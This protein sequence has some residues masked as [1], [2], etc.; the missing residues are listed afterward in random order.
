MRRFLDRWVVGR[1]AGRSSSDGLRC[2]QNGAWGLSGIGCAALGLMRGAFWSGCAAP[3]QALGPGRYI[4]HPARLQGGQVGWDFGKNRR[5]GV[6]FS[7]RRKFFP[8]C[9]V[10]FRRHLVLSRLR[11][12]RTGC[13][14]P[15]EVGCRGVGTG[16]GFR[17][18]LR[19]RGPARTCGVGRAG[20]CWA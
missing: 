13:L 5:L 7:S 12:G 9:R 6:Y 4:R 17:G 18:R 20:F 14:L 3:G 15:S 19:V 2:A 8:S 10:L 11:W 1:Y 16:R